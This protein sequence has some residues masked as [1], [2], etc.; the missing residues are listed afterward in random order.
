MPMFAYIHEN[1]FNCPSKRA[2]FF[3]VLK[4]RTRASFP[5]FQPSARRLLKAYIEPTPYVENVENRV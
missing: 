3:F 5:S 2:L 1:T 4:R